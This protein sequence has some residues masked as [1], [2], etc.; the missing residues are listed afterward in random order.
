MKNSGLKNVFL[1]FISAVLGAGVL[2]LGM[3]FFPDTFGKVIT[4]TVETKNVSITDEGIAE[5]VDKIYDAVVVVK[6]YK[7]KELYSTGTGFVY[8]VDGKTAHILTNNHVIESGDEVYVQFTDGNSVK[9][10]VLGGDKYAD[11]AVL[12]I[13]ANDSVKVASLGSSESI[14]VG[15]T[16]FAVGAPLDAST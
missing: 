11:I 13:S 7:N 14:R 12:S 10:E 4:E 3:Y 8:E 15:D 1:C 16:V 6:T 5:A 2:F 9:V